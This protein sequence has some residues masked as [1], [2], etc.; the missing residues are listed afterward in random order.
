MRNRRPAIAATL[1]ATAVVLAGVVMPTSAQA[2][3]LVGACYDYPVK[4]LQA[5]SS[6][7]PA[8]GCEAPHTAE[9][10]YVRTLPDS[11]GRPSKSSLGARIS[12]AKPCTTAALNAYVGMPDRALPSRFLSVSLVPTDAQWAAGER[13]LRCDVAMLE[14]SEFA[15]FAGTAAAYVAAQP[16]DT[17]N[18]CTRGTPD[19]LKAKAFACT[20]PKKNWGT[21]PPPDLNW[22]KVLEKQLGSAGSKFPGDSSVLKQSYALCHKAGKVWKGKQPYPGWWR[23]YPTASGWKKGRR[24]IQCFVPYGQYLEHLAMTAPKPTPTP[25]PTAT[26]TATPDASPTPAPSA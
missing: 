26:P 21:N 20:A 18:Y 2:A 14:G 23:I 25:A 12:A 6:A 3:P 24:S 22:I 1:A 5:T 10:Y 15:H 8:I 4:T 11:F 9:T 16:Q 7:A 17:F 19:P 13:W